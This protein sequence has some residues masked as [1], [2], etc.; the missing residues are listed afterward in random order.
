MHCLSTAQED[1]PDDEGK[2]VRIRP[3]KCELSANLGDTSWDHK[4]RGTSRQMSDK[5][6]K[7]AQARGHFANTS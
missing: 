1:I 6:A 2:N 3:F 7:L 5:V 4:R